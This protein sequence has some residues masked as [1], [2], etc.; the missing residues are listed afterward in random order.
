[1]RARSNG[2]NQQAAADLMSDL[3]Q[4]VLLASYCEQHPTICTLAAGR[5][6]ISNR[7][8]NGLVEHDAVRKV[9]KRFLVHRTRFTQFR[10]GEFA[11]DRRS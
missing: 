8:V 4:W 3:D 2:A 9:G 6:D 7:A 1:M 10:M 11:R 5:R